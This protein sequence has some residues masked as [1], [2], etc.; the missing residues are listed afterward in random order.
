MLPHRI[1]RLLAT[2]LDEVLQTVDNV[3]GQKIFRSFAKGNIQ[4]DQNL[5]ASDCNGAIVFP[6]TA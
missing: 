1:V 6:V 2:K 5:F 3:L 4:V